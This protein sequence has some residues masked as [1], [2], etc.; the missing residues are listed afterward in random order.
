M[1]NICISSDSTSDLTKKIL[2][3]RHIPIIPLHVLLG[4]DEYSDGVDITPAN[5]F[6]FVKENNILPKTSAT[7]VFEF[8]QYFENLLKEYDYVIHFDISSEI[9]ST[10]QN[11]CLA[12]EEF[13]GRVKVIDSRNLSTGIG[14]LVLKACD[15]RDEGKSFEEICAWAEKKR[16]EVQTSFV[17]DTVDYLHKGGR[18]S[19]AALLA[20][21]LFG[22]HPSIDMRDGKLI[23]D[24]KYRG[25]LKKCIEKYVLKLKVKY[26]KYDKTRCFI[27]H[28]SCSDEIVNDIVELVKNNFEFEEI[29]PTFAGSVITS[30]CGQGTLGVLFLKEE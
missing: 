5:I 13:S 20:T 10:Y 14:A 3:E 6:A 9:S 18:C 15:M 21:R 11:G 1:S 28:S 7:S 29:I 22:I 24:E 30:H 23:A 12:A 8:H 17:V 25:S 27:T 16:F 4:K 19:S 2:Q 26:P